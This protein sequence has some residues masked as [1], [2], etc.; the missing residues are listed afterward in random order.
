VSDAFVHGI[1]RHTKPGIMLSEALPNDL[2]TS[3]PLE[4]RDSISSMI[5]KRHEIV[6]HVY[7]VSQARSEG[8][9]NGTTSPNLP[10]ARVTRHDPTAL[11]RWGLR[12]QEDYACNL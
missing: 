8:T 7:V 3:I 2:P 5:G 4:I 10:F 1:F 11:T 9:S 6:D 12:E